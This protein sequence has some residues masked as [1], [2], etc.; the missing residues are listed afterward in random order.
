MWSRYHSS[1]WS[2]I[3]DD[4][5]EAKHTCHA[6]P[7]LQLIIRNQHLNIPLPLVRKHR[8]PEQKSPFKHQARHNTRKTFSDAGERNV[9]ALPEIINKSVVLFGGI[10]HNHK[11]L[12]IW[13]AVGI[14]LQ[15]RR[16]KHKSSCQ[17]WQRSSSR[18]KE[19]KSY[20]FFLI[21]F[22]FSVVC[23]GHRLESDR[24][25]RQW[26]QRLVD[27]NKMFPRKQRQIYLN[28]AEHDVALT[29]DIS[30]TRGVNFWHLELNVCVSAT[31]K[32]RT[33][34]QTVSGFCVSQVNGN[35]KTE[36]ACAD[37]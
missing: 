24:V 35:T 34:K 28:S 33:G 19:A 29:A 36:P 5:I 26:D 7:S 20:W 16:Q 3:H 18:I 8:P 31:T 30:T 14:Q 27:A 11:Y 9:S 10:T 4:G 37:E 21:S 22:F 23:V 1:V 13:K 2:A 6:L 15:M 25:R 12:L 32:E 17:V